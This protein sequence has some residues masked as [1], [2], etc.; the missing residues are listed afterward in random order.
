MKSIIGYI[1][2]SVTTI[3]ILSLHSCDFLNVNDYFN[4]TLKY[5][6]VF[7]NKY[8]LE[9][10]LWATAALFPDEGNIRTGE[11]GAFACDESFATTNDFPGMQYVLG[12]VTPTNTAGMSKWV[13]MYI[14]IRKANTILANMDR[15]ADMTALDK[16]EYM[17]YTYF[18][19]AYAY[20]LLLMQYGPLVIVGDD[21]MDTNAEAEFYDKARETFDNSVDYVCSEMERAARY[22]PATV[23]VS[24]FGRPS[25]GAALGLAA[26]LRLI[27]ASP[28]WN[29]GEA[30][31][32]T[33][34]NW[35]R[36]T[37][38]VNYVSQTP[39][40]GK[41]AV[42]AM[43]CKRVID[44]NLYSLHTVAKM[45]TTGPLPANVPNLPFP[46]GAGDIDPF[47]SYSDMFTG[48]TLPSKNP[49]YLWGR[50]SGNITASTQYS[51][52]IVNLGG[53][54]C[55]LVTQKV[56]DAYLMAD[57]RTIDDSSAEYPYSTTGFMEGSNR[58]FSGYRLNNTVSNMYVN[59]EMRFYASIGFSECFWPCNSTSENARKNQTVTYHYDGN[60]G[61][62]NINPN[63]PTNYP[64][65]GYVLKK[66]IHADDAW[67]GA[68]AK[69]IDKGF[70]IIRYAEI[71]L[72]YVEA[73]N[74]LTTTHTVQDG[75]EDGQSYTLTRDVDEMRK[76]FNMV[77]FRAGLPGLTDE[78]L[79]SASTMQAL[80][81]RERM[82]ELLFEN[83]RFYDV[84]RW[85]KYESTENEPVMGMDTESTRTGGY[86][87]TVPVNHSWAR[88]RI[89][90]RKL[91]LFPIELDEVRKAPSMDQ[92]PGYQN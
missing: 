3:V 40:E 70:P 47:M 29:G 30:A 48:E 64:F 21:V 65:T 5:D 74:N 56:V 19:R 57:G 11:P 67:S 62:M 73:L 25:K 83:R 35:K 27:Q 42:A 41:W 92:N 71:L 6:S 37:D 53:W 54:N 69:R 20:Y 81:E 63:Y 58:S 72:S 44:M 36:S 39:D 16:M 17:G 79:G 90:D 52:P 1:V 84:R 76:Y 4:D 34:G 14:I 28:L 66:F 23:P 50:M 86:Y 12:N 9:R 61:K 8:N 45:P 18:L 78:E 46:D 51:F 24:Y 80:V 49:E 55:L 85:G 7:Q 31:R 91:I 60:A 26:R 15:A 33:F 10:Y 38:N 88:N 43:A 89:V 13:N 68:N 82:V 22:L 2:A 32:R 59:R 77:R 75:E 87:S